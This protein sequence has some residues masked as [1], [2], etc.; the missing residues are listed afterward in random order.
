MILTKKNYRVYC[1]LL[2][3]FLPHTLSLADGFIV[4]FDRPSECFQFSVKQSVQWSCAHRERFIL[5]EDAIALEQY[6]LKKAQM[7]K[8]IE[9]LLNQGDAY[10]EVGNYPKAEQAFR[11]GLQLNAASPTAWLR[12]AS[13]YNN[14]NREADALQTLENGLEQVPDNADIYYEMGLLQVR[15][16][17]LSKAIVSLAKA[18]LL[19]QENSHYSYVY[20]IAM[21]SYQ[22]PDEALDIL[23]QAYLLH[24]EDENILTALIS[25]NQDNKHNIE[26]LKY[27]KKLLALDP[28]N[29]SLQNF[30]EQLKPDKK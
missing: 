6:E 26:A 19:A 1:V 24:P 4:E 10:Y 23:Q 9:N 17:L 28:D 27:A 11:Q 14:L 21:N 15:L 8:R 22:R 12:L 3:S 16:R 30:V 18:A 2:I 29:P 5:D 13:F 20:A 25:I 7:L